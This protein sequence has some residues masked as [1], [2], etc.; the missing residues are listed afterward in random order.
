MKKVLICIFL[1]ATTIVAYSQSSKNKNDASTPKN[2]FIDYEF[3]PKFPGGEDALKAFIKNN[4]RWPKMWLKWRA[5]LYYPSLS[6]K[7]EV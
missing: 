4:L 2:A 7:M 6:K 3:S 1:I 5:K